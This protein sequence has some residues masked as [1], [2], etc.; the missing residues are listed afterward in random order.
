MTAV[1]LGLGVGLP[2]YSADRQESV[3]YG[4]MLSCATDE[5]HRLLP[6]LYRMVG[7]RRRYSV[8]LE[9]PSDCAT[10]RQSFYP[11][12]NGPDDKGPTVGTRM[13]RYAT[14]AGPLAETA[15]RAALTDAR[16]AAESITHLV[17]VSCSGFAAPG[18]DHA[19]IERLGL[20]STVE[21][22][23]VG[24]MGCH[25]ALNGLRV[26]KGLAADAGSGARILLCAVELCS[27]HYHYG[28][29]PEQVVANALFADGAAAAVV[30]ADGTPAYEQAWRVHATGSCL[31]PNS[32]DA[33][34]WRIGDHGFEMTLSAR[35]PEL[36]A[37]NLPGWIA[38]W[39]DKHGL[40]LTDIASWAVHPGG[41]RILN[42]VDKCLGLGDG[43]L[44]VSR[45]VL[46]DYGNMSSP[47]TLFILKQF[48]DAAAETPCVALGFGPG[49]TA[50][51]VLFT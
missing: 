41:P 2:S 21:R 50:E 3:A 30:G 5:Q 32:E 47:T 37:D 43:A 10:E 25:G 51:A 22:V 17:T 28:W 12:P 45:S 36:I 13:Q 39:L 33:M 38:S 35:V 20:P 31:I 34:T 16:C 23:N 9:A 15:S 14:E 4:R 7:V 26:A 44:D 11:P 18:I 29:D 48:R 46:R 40:A 8:I 27:L 24:F 42:A 19:L 1:L 49:L 6:A